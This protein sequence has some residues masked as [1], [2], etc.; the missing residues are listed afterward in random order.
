MTFFD[1]YILCTT[2]R[3]GSTFLCGLLR[4]TGCAGDPQSYFHR[5]SLA[6]WRDGLHL[7]ADCNLKSIFDQARHV[8]SGNSDIFGLRLQRHSFDFWMTQLTALHP[9]QSSDVGRIEKAFGTTAFIHL[10]RQDKIAQAVSL[11]RAAQS[12]LWHRN[13]DGSELERLKPSQELHY[14]RAAISREMAELTAF[15]HAWRDWFETEN[16][17]PINIDYET[18]AAAPADTIHQIFDHLGLDVNQVQNLEP[19]TA[20]LADDINLEW[21]R[22]FMRETA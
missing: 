1:S 12:G 19:P 22:K 11:V 3:S 4:K 17:T 18:L 16:I 9:E 10:T 15:D 8:G 5:P 13:A 7:A 6:D 14:D 20:Q 21:A 2:P